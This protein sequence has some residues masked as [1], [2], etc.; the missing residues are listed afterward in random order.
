V[1][2]DEFLEFYR[3]L[4]PTNGWTVTHIG[5]ITNHVDCGSEVCVIINKGNTQI[6]LFHY[7][8]FIGADHDTLH[9]FDD[10]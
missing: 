4:T 5:Q 8:G 10:P 7:E 3:N 6:I 9:R 2:H 1:S